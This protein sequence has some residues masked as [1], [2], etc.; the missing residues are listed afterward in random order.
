[1][2]SIG[3]LRSGMGV[4]LDGEPHLIIEAQHSKQARGSGV[5]KTKVK[6]LITGSI[7]NKTFQGNEKIE[8]ADLT[9]SKAQFLY[10]DNESFKFMDNSTFEQFSLDNE[11]VGDQAHFLVDGMDVDI[12]RF[13]ETPIAVKLPPKVDLEVTKTDP[14]V[15][16]DT[17]S[18]GTKPATVET[19]YTLQVPLFIDTGEKIRINTE[20]GEYVERA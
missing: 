15:R 10:S 14:D 12:Q 17:A 2:Y 20:S 8:P 13:E 5:T 6:N 9:H 19:G 4:V 16:G 11:T 7:V 18:G 3:Q 1:M